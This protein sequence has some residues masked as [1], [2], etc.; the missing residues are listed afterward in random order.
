M[1]TLEEY[2]ADYIRKVTK[3]PVVIVA[4]EIKK[5]IRQYEKDYL[6]KVNVE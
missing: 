1:G 2:I 5:A 3:E 4:I 6:V